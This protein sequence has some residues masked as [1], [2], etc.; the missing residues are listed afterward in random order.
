M[1]RIRVENYFATNLKYLRAQKGW[2]GK[3]LAS[4]VGLKQHTSI[5]LYEAGTGEPTISIC[6]KIAKIFNIT[7][8][9]LIL[10]PQNQWKQKNSNN[11]DSKKSDPTRLTKITSF[12]EKTSSIHS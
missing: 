6:L 3:K 1:K 9:D 8:E 2:S 5:R 4:M 10:K 7:L 12:L 11:S